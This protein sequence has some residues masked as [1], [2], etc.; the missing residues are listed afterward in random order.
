MGG[1][2]RDKTSPR[3]IA[4]SPQETPFDDELAQLEDV[5]REFEYTMRSAEE[6]A[7]VIQMEKY[8]LASFSAADYMYE[9]QSLVHGMF[10]DERPFFMHLGGFF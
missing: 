1:M 10:A 2:T 4:E 8:G 7:D 5:A 9:I 6:D 3:A